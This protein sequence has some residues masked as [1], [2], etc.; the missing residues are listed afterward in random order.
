MS[1]SRR[2]TR[3]RLSETASSAAGDHGDG[4][5]PLALSAVL[6]GPLARRVPAFVLGFERRWNVFGPDSLMQD[7]SY[8]VLAK[9]ANGSEINL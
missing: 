8:V 6:A 4:D 9:L 5:L 3:S 1:T 7:C 2:E